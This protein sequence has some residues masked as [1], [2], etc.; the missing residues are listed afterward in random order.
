MSKDG[1]QNWT[2]Y[3]ELM[4][5]RLLL[6]TDIDSLI[7]VLADVRNIPVALST[8]E[9]VTDGTGLNMSLSVI[10]SEVKVAGRV[11]CLVSDDMFTSVQL[12]LDTV[13]TVYSK[14]SVDG[15]GVVMKLTIKNGAEF[16]LMFH[17]EFVEEEMP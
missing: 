12:N 6:V 3:L 14:I 8:V 9:D 1:M 15:K 13:K 10:C 7:T 4:R 16:L 17:T 5:N 2:N 11:M